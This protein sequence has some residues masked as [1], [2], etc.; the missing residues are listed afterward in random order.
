MR[1][2]FIIDR[3]TRWR[4]NNY[5]ASVLEWSQTVSIKKWG[6][7]PK[8]PD[9]EYVSRWPANFRG[10]LGCGH[11]QYHFNSC[12]QSADKTIKVH[13]DR[14]YGATFLLHGRVMRETGRIERSDC[15][16]SCMLLSQLITLR[17]KQTSKHLVGVKASILRHWWI[18]TNNNKQTTT[19]PIGK[20]RRE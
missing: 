14:N 9:N 16:V 10:C 2:F 11:S 5:Y 3:V 8:N 7:I 18:G 19:S 4:R 12:P 17:R 15:I 1:R 13:I 6:A 20:E